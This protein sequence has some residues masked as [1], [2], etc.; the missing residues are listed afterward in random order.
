MSDQ[1]RAN[2]NM[3]S[4]ILNPK[5]KFYNELKRQ[6]D[7]D[8]ED[9]HWSED[10]IVLERNSRDFVTRVERINTGAEAICDV[11]RAHPRGKL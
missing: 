1:S 9:N 2:T 6:W 8:Y 11:L 10:S 7:Q 4:L 5:G 3:S